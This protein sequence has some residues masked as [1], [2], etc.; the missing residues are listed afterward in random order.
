MI[1]EEQPDCSITSYIFCDSLS[2]NRLA[3][4]CPND[5]IFVLVDKKRLRSSV[6]SSAI[7]NMAKL[8]TRD[9][10][11]VLL[12][13]FGHNFASLADEYMDRYYEDW[14]EAED[15]PNCDY[16]ECSSWS[17]INGTDCIRGCSTNKFYRSIDVSIMR[18]YDKSNEYGI[19]NEQIIEQNLEEY[20]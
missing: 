3:S 12:H 20:R 11:L 10:R 18:D 2:V 5:Y 15:Y 1:D 6:R 8:N 7:S 19:L 17:S 4:N 14:F 13:E 9:N 16:E